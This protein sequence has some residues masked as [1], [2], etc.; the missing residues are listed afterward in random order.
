MAAKMKV[1]D[2]DTND[3][4][5]TEG[6][7]A[8]HEQIYNEPTDIEA[9]RIEPTESLGVELEKQTFKLELEGEQIK[10]N[11][12]RTVRTQQLVPCPDCGKNGYR[13]NI[14]VLAYKHVNTKKVMK[15]KNFKNTP[16]RY[17]RKCK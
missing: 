2:L 13:Q 15:L 9:I 6:N 11:D 17:S 10:Q 3:N 5:N 1:A 16:K 8:I 14:Q 12:G 4:E 7:E